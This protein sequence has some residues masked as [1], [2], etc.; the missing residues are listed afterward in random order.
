[1]KPSAV[2]GSADTALNRICPYFTMFP[3]RFPYGILRR[4][5]ADQDI[6]LDPFCGRGTTNYAARL[7]SLRSYGIDVNPVAVA[8]ARAKAFHVTPVAIIAE[9]DALL[10]ATGAAKTPI[11]EFWH[12]AFHPEVLAIIGRLR[13]ALINA[14]RT[15]TRDALRGLVLGALH[16]PR[17]KQ[18]SSY[19]SNQSPR[20]FAPKP[21]Y[22][23][24]FW[25][26]RNMRPE[27]VDIR[28]VLARR[29]QRYYAGEAGRGASTIELGDAR[30]RDVLQA[31]VGHVR[32]VITSPP[33]YGMRTYLPDQWLRAWFLGGPASP[34]YRDKA[35]LRHLSPEA[36]AR[37][38]GDVWRNVRAISRP[39]AR[40][41][42]RFGGITDR[43][44]D[45]REVL[46]ASLRDSGWRVITRRSAGVAPRARR[47]ADHFQRQPARGV[48]EFDTWAAA[49]A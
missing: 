46:S 2:D 17:S 47:Q 39:D 35:Q 32:W 5:A 27:P 12:W 10:A 25:R 22:A 14:E 34:I 11:G 43:S 45:P 23:I 48:A 4:H 21:D 16:G 6:V 30:D 28:L 13:H 3:L 9:Y 41:V 36:F 1:V 19:L 20:T 26:E 38:L 42:I 24:R 15:P 8:I 44:A 18:T 40:L 37:D 31:I 33:Y 49:I 7:R 29:A